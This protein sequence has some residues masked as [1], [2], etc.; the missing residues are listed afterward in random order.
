MIHL[1]RL[2][3]YNSRYLH[4]DSRRR[5]ACLGQQE[6]GEKEYID[7]NYGK[8]LRSI[9]GAADNANSIMTFGAAVEG[10]ALPEN[11]LYVGINKGDN[12][13]P[14]IK[15]FDWNGIT[16]IT[17]SGYGSGSLRKPGVRK[18][19]M[20]YQNKGPWDYMDS[21]DVFIE[22]TGDIKEDPSG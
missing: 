12:K 20:I 14:V 21:F 18:N 1:E 11:V 22:Y 10:L 2:S 9:D 5:F 7:N 3:D 6:Y 13:T 17:I 15:R 4:I 16:R 19:I 8:L